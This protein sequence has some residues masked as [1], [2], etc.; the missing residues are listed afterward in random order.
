MTHNNDLEK[1]LYDLIKQ[2]SKDNSPIVFKGGLALKELLYIKNS[3][4]N[5]DRKT[6]DIDGNWIENYDLEKI[7]KTLE[8]S[9]KKINNNYK[10][11]ITREPEKNRSMGYKIL[12]ENNDILT[13]IDLDIKDNPFYIICSID[14]IDIK[15][16]SPEKML[17][18]KLRSISSKHIFRRIKDI[19]DIYLIIN[20]F[21]IDS[22][23]IHEILKFENKELD[24]FS[25]M[26][27]NKDTIKEIYNKMQG[28]INKP[29]FDEV[30]KKIINYL[31]KEKFIK[32]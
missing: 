23:K 18:D 19:L 27:N 22:N 17:T 2:L 6:I 10:L 29:L 16:S 28:I 12:D 20:N 31:I 9:L 24:D 4:L 25:T 13:K 11:I 1:I 15:Y 7:T 8:K 32:Y 26:L 3:N 30:W 5:I 21:N 14:N